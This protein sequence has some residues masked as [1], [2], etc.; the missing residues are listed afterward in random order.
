LSA[1]Q[2]SLFIL[3]V[4]LPTSACW[5]AEQSPGQV[6]VQTPETQIV[7]SARSVLHDIMAVPAKQIPQSLLSRAEG[8]AIVPNVVKG[9]F[10]VGVRRG[11]GVLLVRDD[12]GRWHPPAF[13]TLTGG[14]IGW[15]AGIQST[16]VILVFR[17]RNSITNLMNENLTIGVD[18]AASAGP[19][20]RNVA[21]STDATLKAEI[22]SYSRSRGLF[23][24]ASID[25]SVIS[26]D[27]AAGASYYGNLGNA[28]PGQPTSLPHSAVQLITQ[29]ARYSGGW[30]PVAGPGP[31]VPARHPAPP[32]P[33]ST[34]RQLIASYAALQ[35]LLDAQW[36]AHLKLPPELAVNGQTPRI[37]EFKQALQR[38]EVVAADE[39][40]VALTRRTEFTTTL[41]LLRA[42]VTSLA[43]KSA[44]TLNLPPPPT[45]TR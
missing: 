41:R 15:Q 43:E 9:G 35:K 7:E 13:I 29:L 16:D 31:P 22:L 36:N 33:E 8:V 44:S 11:R 6:V 34:R 37:G 5:F 14:S 23:A 28:A 12:Q 40:Y 10:V 19:V 21:A 30:Q 26:V 18:A 32:D 25:G 2:K 1:M 45:A 20:G 3:A 4:C 17:T 38:Y 27:Y 42:Y 39:R 24:G